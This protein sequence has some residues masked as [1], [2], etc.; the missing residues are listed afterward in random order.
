MS[1]RRGPRLETRFYTLNK[2]ISEDGR[3]SWAARGV[4][5]F[6]LGK[7]D[8]WEVSVKHLINQTTE[9]IGKASGRDAVRV[10]LKE[11]EQ[12]GYLVADVARNEGGAFNGMA[13]TVC[14]I[15]EPQTE[16][17]GPDIPA[18]GKPAPANPP[19][20][21]NDLNQG[22]DTP[23]NTESLGAS[24][25]CDGFEAAWKV[26]PKREGSSVKSKAHSCWKARLKDGVTAETMMAGVM[27]FAAFCKVKG[28]I[29]TSYVIQGS[30]FFGTALEFENEWS[31]VSTG[32]PSSI[33]KD[34]SNSTYQGTPDD[35]LAEFLQ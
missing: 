8:N 34:F 13:Y 19:L 21:S 17:P 30:R 16:S 12:A 11:L 6:L 10:I 9:A 14:E 29:G 23:E 28:W 26:Y 15:P 31:A 24:A 2:S 25:P 1:I 22:T 32:K 5:I 7:P 18:P 27:R 35:Q 20:T 33:T 3:L 4:L